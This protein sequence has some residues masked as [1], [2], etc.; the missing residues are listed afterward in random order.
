MEIRFY[1]L[2]IMLFN[3]FWGFSQIEEQRKYQIQE[4]ENFKPFILTSGSTNSFSTQFHTKDIY[5]DIYLDSPDHILLN[6]NLSLR[7]RKRVSGTNN[8]TVSYAF[9]LKSEMKSVNQARMEVEES[10]LFFYSIKSDNKWVPLTD[11]LDSIFFPM[12]NNQA[13]TKTESVN[14]AIKQLELWMVF[15]A[16][17][18]IAPFQKLVKLKVG[19]IDQIKSIAP[20]CMGSSIRHRSH[21]YT[22]TN[23]INGFN[24]KQNRVK[25]SELP[26]IFKINSTCNW[27]LESSMDYSTFY[28]IVTSSKNKVNL[29]EYEV[30]N[31]HHMQLEGKK[32]LEIFERELTRTYELTPLVD[33]KYKQ[34]MNSF[35]E[36]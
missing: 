15:K 14:R 36:D 31:K 3:A 29:V 30:E 34:A 8:Q 22:K 24:F 6:N 11:V 17:S 20:V 16:E 2:I 21:I 25:L 26:E 32:A 23:Q 13:F 33:S 35:F 4:I 27:L 19:S 28:P 1:V 9:Q 18:A 10:E 5:Y 7:F 12:E